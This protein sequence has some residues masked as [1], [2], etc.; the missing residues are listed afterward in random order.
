MDSINSHMSKLVVA[1]DKLVEPSTLVRVMSDAK[2][3]EF[4][5]LFAGYHDK[6]IWRKLMF[7]DPG[8]QTIYENARDRRP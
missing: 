4:A 8:H 2:H 5:E 3:M 1:V 7:I 6:Q